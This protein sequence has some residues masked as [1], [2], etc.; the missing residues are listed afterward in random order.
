M[1]S[2]FTRAAKSIISE[3]DPDGDLIPV[4]NLIDSERYKHLCLMVKE[5]LVLYPLRKKSKYVNT[6]FK[7]TDMME[8][9]DP[10][11][12]IE[13]LQ[14][15]SY[16]V[17]EEVG[18]MLAASVDVPDMPI[19]MAIKAGAEIS[20]S[21][22]ILVNKK[23]VT[24]PALESLKDKR[25]IDMSRTPMEEWQYKDKDI[26]VITEIMEIEQDTDI[27][28]SG[29]IE[30]SLNF[31][32]VGI[33]GKGHKK[34]II[35]IPKGSVLGFRAQLL[36]IRNGKWAVSCSPST[37]EKT[38]DNLI[39]HTK[40]DTISVFESLKGFPRAKAEIQGECSSL[41]FLCQEVA[42]D[43]LL[44]AFVFIMKDPK[45][46]TE[47]ETRVEQVRCSGEQYLTAMSK[48]LEYLGISKIPT[49]LYR[50]LIELI[51]FF[52]DALN[53]L[54]ED[55]VFMLM[56]SVE[57]Q[58]TEHQLTQ[59]ETLLAENFISTEEFDDCQISTRESNF[60]PILE[61][62]GGAS[63]SWNLMVQ[64]YYIALYAA[65]CLLHRLSSPTLSTKPKLSSV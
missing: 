56:E 52:L 26:Y 65:L 63:E 48:L 50:D 11:D 42:E 8:A 18:G 1:D 35:H 64:S 20:H 17:T 39:Y 38:F 62:S 49:E 31:F 60:R 54:D 46:I 16:K 23:Y 7:L 10:G 34:S 43:V 28:T 3:L 22:S 61:A 58:N 55:G 13:I 6:G 33:K 24:Q 40:S 47:V 14:S 36:K 59:V 44:K 21:R 30:S 57:K 41:K 32:K 2:T 45:T 37:N 15:K 19:D 51:R 29:S 25:R 5:N 53:E 4:S 27:H 9:G 12:E